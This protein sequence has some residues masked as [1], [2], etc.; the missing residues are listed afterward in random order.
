MHYQGDVNRGLAI[1]GCIPYQE[2]G[3]ARSYGGW[4][5]TMTRRSRFIFLS[6]SLIEDQ[7]PL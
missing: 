5:T 3:Y 2:Y 1:G 4:P 6:L 7:S